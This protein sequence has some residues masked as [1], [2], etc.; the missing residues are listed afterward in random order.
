M[1]YDYD[2]A[3]DELYV[4]NDIGQTCIIMIIILMMIIV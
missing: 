3:Y 4:E 1:G 2:D